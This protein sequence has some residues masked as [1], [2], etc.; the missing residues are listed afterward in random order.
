MLNETLSC[1]K[2]SV[3]IIMLRNN[4]SGSIINYEKD[5]DLPKCWGL[6]RSS[7]GGE[8]AMS[9]SLLGAGTV[10]EK[11]PSCIRSLVFVLELCLVLLR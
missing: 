3:L 2:D 9:S 1:K 5:T 6:G 7:G 4:S 8:S 11:K 10:L